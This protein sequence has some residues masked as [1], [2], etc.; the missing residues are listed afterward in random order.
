VVP[1]I[2][3]L[4][5]DI[6][7]DIEQ[8][9]HDVQGVQNDVDAAIAQVQVLQGQV[10]DI[11]Q[12]DVWTES[13]TYP[14]GDL[15]QYNGKL[16]RSL[17]DANTGHQPSGETDAW[18]EYIGNYA[19]LGEA[20]SATAAQV[21]VIDN[22]VTQQGT[23]ITANSQAI[24]QQAAQIAGKADASALNATNATVT[25]QGQQITAVAQDIALLGAHTS[26][27]SAFVLNQNTV[28][29]DGS[30]TFAQMLSGLR[31]S[32]NA[33]SAAIS[34]ET[35]ARANADTAL[36]QRID[37]VQ[38]TAGSLTAAITAEQTAR[39]NGDSA[40]AAAI[41]SVQSQMPSGTNSLSN[42]G[43]ES[44]AIGSVNGAISTTNFSDGWTML[45][46][47]GTQNYWWSG[48]A[49]SG[50]YG[51]LE[52]VNQN[53]NIPTGAGVYT[54]II[55][56]KVKVSPGDLITFGG[57]A[58]V[59]Q[60]GLPSNCTAVAR[61]GLY[62]ID[63]N[64]TYTEIS[65]NDTTS[66]AWTL[67][68]ENNFVVP[69][70]YSYLVMELCLFIINN[71]GSAFVSGTNQPYAMFDDCYLYVNMATASSVQSL[72]TSVNSLTG[73]VNAS[74]TLQLNANGYVTGWKF[75]NDGT[76]GTFD[77]VADRFSIIT[78]DGRKALQ[79]VNGQ[80]T[81]SSAD[82]GQRL[83][84]TQSLVSVYDANGILRVRLGVW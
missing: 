49:R 67:L 22:T 9:E 40:N 79:Y 53:Q 21:A 50:G 71:T 37:S 15:V 1:P 73:K 76:T 81:I 63:S 38:A 24:Q 68:G 70:G 45:G 32:D 36:G 41:V 7:A 17:Q 82:S 58:S 20:V 39:A 8:L 5:D 84:I 43:F 62:G 19:S 65:M 56:N 29:I 10:G 28:Q 44:N 34:N 42:P 13:K 27:K 55:S 18:W 30:Q 83:V 14:K 69:N 25:Q 26:D 59:S 2:E 61:V 77:V 16:Y 12:A 6:N 48:A 51:L 60:G 52:R 78:P 11:L 33:N 35:T 75:N 3:H 80:L 66:S 46:Y 74:F 31:A 72:T 47:S 54:R 4:F 23:Q 64:D 57:Y